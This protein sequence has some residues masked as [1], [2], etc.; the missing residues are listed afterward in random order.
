MPAITIILNG[1]GAFNDVPPGKIIHTLEPIRVAALA[2]G[3]T[4]GKPSIALGVFLPNGGGCVIAETSLVLFLSAADAM[5]ARY[6][7]PRE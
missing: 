3:M 4:S 1:D 5:K 2:N 7:D 6:G